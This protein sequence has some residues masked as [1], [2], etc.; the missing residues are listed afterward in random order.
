MNLCIR[1]MREPLN[2]TT[3]PRGREESP[4]SLPCAVSW[5]MIEHSANTLFTAASC[6]LSMDFLQVRGPEL[7]SHTTF[8]VAAGTETL[9][10]PLSLKF[11]Q[12]LI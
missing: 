1:L 2:P 9:S 7:E 6:M 5:S 12:L 4:E 8:C 3:E 11:P 10:R